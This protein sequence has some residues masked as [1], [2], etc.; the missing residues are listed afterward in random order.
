[1]AAFREWMTGQRALLAPWS[2]VVHYALCSCSCSL[3]RL[4]AVEN[5]SDLQ[6]QPATKPKR[7]LLRVAYTSTSGVAQV[8]EQ[9]P[10]WPPTSTQARDIGRRCPGGAVGRHRLPQPK[11]SP[12]PLC[13][14]PGPSE[15]A[16]FG[17]AALQAL[18][19][20]GSSSGGR[21][22]C[23]QRT[24]RRPQTTRRLGGTSS[25]SCGVRWRAGAGGLARSG[26]L[27]G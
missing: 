19:L 17:L 3:F 26:A 11:L 14:P 7:A 24:G 20:R 8:G 22:P 5:I 9:S 16:V 1:M 2:A 18:G 6:L 25:A 4:C 15:N 23:S 13:A 10:G 21:R 12:G 27:G